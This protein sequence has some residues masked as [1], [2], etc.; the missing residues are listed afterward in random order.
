MASV[1]AEDSRFASVL[2]GFRVAGALI[3]LALA[4]AGRNPCH[5]DR[6]FALGKRCRS[7]I[8]VKLL[9]GPQPCLEEFARGPGVLF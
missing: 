4:A 6:L 9:V 8:Q 7:V 1:D 2:L 3:V 5:R